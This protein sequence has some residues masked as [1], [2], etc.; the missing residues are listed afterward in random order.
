MSKFYERASA[1]KSRERSVDSNRGILQP[2]SQRDDT[3]KTM[4][5]SHLADGPGRTV[6]TRQPIAHGA[7]AMSPTPKRLQKILLPFWPVKGR[8]R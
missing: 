8:R 2:Q 3:P 6:A 7:P 1:R 5:S 4:V